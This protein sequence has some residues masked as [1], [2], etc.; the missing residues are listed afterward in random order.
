M[1][2][3]SDEKVGNDILGR[4]KARGFSLKKRK[5]WCKNLQDLSL[6]ISTYITRKI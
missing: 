5:L 6:K 1:K 3:K 4:I 2:N